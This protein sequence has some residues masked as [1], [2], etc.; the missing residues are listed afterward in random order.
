MTK[1]KD[2]GGVISE[3]AV[4]CPHCGARGPGEN[5]FVRIVKR[6]QI[7]CAVMAVIIFLISLWVR[8]L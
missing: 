3:N 2:C 7:G 8:Y 1:C 5:G 6:G 4:R